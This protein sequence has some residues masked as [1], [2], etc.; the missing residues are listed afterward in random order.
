MSEA[1]AAWVISLCES[2]LAI[3]STSNPIATKGIFIRGRYKYVREYDK[4]VGLDA[5]LG[6]ICHAF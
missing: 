5:R 1:G 3:I 4:D 2:L 6:L